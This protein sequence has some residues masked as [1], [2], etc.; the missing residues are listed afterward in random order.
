MN[1]FIYYYS[2]TDT[3]PE[4]LICCINSSL[5]S[6][7]STFVATSQKIAD[8]LTKHPACIRGKLI[9][10][11]V[12]EY[13]IY[14]DRIIKTYNLF[15]DNG[16]ITSNSPATEIHCIYRWIAMRNVFQEENVER[17]VMLDWDTFVFEFP[18]VDFNQY[19]FIYAETNDRDRLPAWHVCPHLMLLTQ[20]VLE[21]YLSYFEKTLRKRRSQ[22]DNYF[23]DMETW[24]HVISR[25]YTQKGT[26]KFTYSTWQELLENAKYIYDGNIRLDKDLETKYEQ[27]KFTIAKNTP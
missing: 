12:N 14:E 21:V 23:C 18:K 1:G 5:R 26:N 20:S 6:F 2:E 11:V 17:L 22:I 3:V 15:V 10:K 8:E 4:L 24:S 25:C 9:I 7:D 13:D 27:S 19:D 16:W